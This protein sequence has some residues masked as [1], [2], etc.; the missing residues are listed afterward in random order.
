MRAARAI[1]S[2]LLLAALAA[3]GC[4]DR[5]FVIESNVPNAQVYIDNRPVGAAPVNA[6]FD[7][8]GYYNVTL[9]HPD[10][11]T[12]NKRMRSP[13]AVVRLPAVRLF[14]R[15]P[16]ALPRRGRPPVLLQAGAGADG[17][18]QRAH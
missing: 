1:P 13:G 16:V 11:A 10:F 3:A 7:Y 4:V 6:P 12:T 2:A 15:G 9:V 14:R 17:A 5:R 18:E 8:Y